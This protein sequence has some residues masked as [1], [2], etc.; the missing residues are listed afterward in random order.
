MTAPDTTVVRPRGS[1]LDELTAACVR[2]R[3]TFLRYAPSLVILLVAADFLEP[4]LST[5]L[6][7]TPILGLILFLLL[8][9]LAILVL[10]VLTW[11]LLRAACP[12]CGRSFFLR[13]HGGPTPVGR[14]LVISTLFE[15]ELRCANCGVTVEHERG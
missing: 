5:L 7:H 14:Y 12:W 10:F 9:P 6:D 4:A 2:R 3:R 13:T 15:S 8:L 1:R 11:R